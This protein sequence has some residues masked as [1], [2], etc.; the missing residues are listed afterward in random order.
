M[1]D[2]NLYRT[3]VV[4]G[5]W[6][7]NAYLG[8]V[9][10]SVIVTSALDYGYETSILLVSLVSFCYGIVIFVTLVPHPGEIGDYIILKRIG[11]KKSVLKIVSL[12]FNWLRFQSPAS[13][14][15]K[16]IFTFSRLF[17]DCASI[18]LIKI[19]LFNNK[20][21]ITT[22]VCRVLT[23]LRMKTGWTPRPL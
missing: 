10:G 13:G 22:K 1:S 3:G 11:R 18:A 23:K 9:I 2:L 12:I 20:K 7:V 19:I 8:N 16:L 5:F 21:C 14:F 17:K 15:E 6:G 4:F